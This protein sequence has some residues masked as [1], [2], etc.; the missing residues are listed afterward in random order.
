MLI[1]T[2]VL[3]W[4]L[5][6]DEEALP[7]KVTALFSLPDVDVVVSAAVVWEISIKRGLGKLVAPK[8]LVHVLEHAGVTT[9]SMTARHAEIAGALPN[10]HRDPFDRMLI[11][12]ASAEG[13]PIITSDAQIARYDVETIWN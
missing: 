8:N 5:D 3:L 1:D 13:I 7:K 6:A 9:L 10:V 2:H 11:A 12:Q 4:W